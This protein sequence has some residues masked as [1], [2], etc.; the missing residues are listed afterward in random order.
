MTFV[1]RNGVSASKKIIPK[2]GREA[3][4]SVDEENHPVSRFSVDACS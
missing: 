3:H 1:F 2:S 4:E